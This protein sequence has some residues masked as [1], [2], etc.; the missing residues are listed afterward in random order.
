MPQGFATLFLLQLAC[1][2]ANAWVQT[3]PTAS[4]RHVTL[5]AEGKSRR[6]AVSAGLSAAVAAVVASTPAF[7]DEEFEYPENPVFREK[8]SFLTMSVGRFVAN[9]ATLIVS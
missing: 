2:T 6:E 8:V 1:L 9:A 3:A 4:R 5:Q 7:A